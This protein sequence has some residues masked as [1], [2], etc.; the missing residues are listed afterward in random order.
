MTGSFTIYT[1]PLREFHYAP[2]YK[3]FSPGMPVP[4]ASYSST[5]P[6]GPGKFMMGLPQ[7]EAQVKVNLFLD[8]AGNPKETFLTPRPTASVGTQNCL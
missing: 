6:D 1:T 8:I 4:I 2:S 7:P 3:G 5:Y